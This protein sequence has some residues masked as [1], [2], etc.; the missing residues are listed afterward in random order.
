[1]MLAPFGVRSFRFQWPADL[2]ASW[3]IEMEALILG[4]YVLIATG[5][6]QQLVLFASLAWIGSLFSPFFGLLADRIGYRPLL[7]ATRGLYALLAMLITALAFAQALVPWHVFAIAAIVGLIRPSDNLMRNVL[8]G[9]TIERPMLLGALGISR[10]TGD[11]AKVI[12]AFAGTGTVAWLGLGPAYA[13]VSTL[14]VAAFVLS[15]GVAG[16]PPAAR[17]GNVE[18]AAAEVLNGLKQ[19]VRYVWRTP[20]QL[21][22]FSIAFLVNLLAYPLALGLLPYVAKD[23]FG[24]GQ[25]G[26]GYLA[27]AFALGALS[28]SVLLIAR[29]FPLRAARAMLCGGTVWFGLILAFGQVRSLEAGLVLLFLGG[30]AQS[31]C[32]VPLAA[33]M[34]RSASEEMRGRVMG[35]RMLAVWGLPLGIL[36]AGPL[37]ERLGYVAWT[38]VYGGLGLAAMLAIGYRWR[39]ALWSRS[40]PANSY[41]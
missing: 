8:I 23:V 24:A 29:R 33:V 30:L 16:A 20:E 7:C 21:G 11:T 3:A 27:A 5:S 35:M 38:M 14:Y 28:G 39:A 36:A 26:L 22:A 31:F 32:L 25:T 37:I 4:W 10:T 9:Q 40:A 15:L 41:S 2:A 18:A 19:G 6:V 12:G 13:I 17:R 1:M 34:L